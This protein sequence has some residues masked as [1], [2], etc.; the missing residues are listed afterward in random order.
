MSPDECAC[1]CHLSS[2]LTGV[3]DQC[4]PECDPDAYDLCA[5]GAPR[6]DHP[7]ESPGL[8]REGACERFRVPPPVYLRQA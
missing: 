8:R 1:R 4:C 6:Y 3:H 5:C 2:N 7:F